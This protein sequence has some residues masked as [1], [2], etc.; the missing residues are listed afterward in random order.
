MQEITSKGSPFR[1]TER[2]GIVYV[3]NEYVSWGHDPARGGEICSAVVKYGS[4]K[5]LLVNPQYTE[6]A[7]YIPKG[8]C[9]YHSYRTVQSAA[10]DFNTEEKDGMVRVSFHSRLTDEKGEELDGVTVSHEAEYH[11][12]GSVFHKVTLHL[13]KEMAP[14]LVT[15]G[16]LDII[17]TMNM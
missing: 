8:W 1:V 13:T 10:E 5:N 11:I 15:V 2:D 4:G 14:S 17:N 12:Y 9:T 3:E 6:L 7:Y 16:A